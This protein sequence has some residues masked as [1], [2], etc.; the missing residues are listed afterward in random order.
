MC[1]LCFIIYIGN[2]S[3]GD[4][5]TLKAL[6]DFYYS[7]D[8]DKVENNIIEDDE[9]NRTKFLSTSTQQSN[10]FKFLFKKG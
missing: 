3:K 1:G 8:D 6:K 10:I 9:K 2:Q 4:I 7:F 5:N